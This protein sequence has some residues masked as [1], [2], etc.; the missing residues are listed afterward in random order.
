MKSEK[1]TKNIQQF[2]ML[3]Y[4]WTIK[5]LAMQTEMYIEIIKE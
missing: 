3:N 1:S 4:A 2:E 5:V